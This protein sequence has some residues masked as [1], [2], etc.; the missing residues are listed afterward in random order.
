MASR[1]TRNR[2]RWFLRPSCDDDGGLAANPTGASVDVD[3]DNHVPTFLSTSSSDDGEN[4]ISDESS[5]DSDG[6]DTH[7]HTEELMNWSSTGRD[8]ASVTGDS[9]SLEDG[10]E[11]TVDSVASVDVASQPCLDLSTSEEA[12]VKLL[13]LLDGSSAPRKL[14]DKVVTL[15][16][17]LVNDGADPT[18]LY[19]RD[20]LM[21]KL[22]SQISVPN[23]WPDH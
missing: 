7:D 11:I 6:I 4:S 20:R 19:S 21:R 14:Y 8:D 10:D 12:S 3:A 1:A 23:P 18:K 16:R 2:R 9:A 5:E 17:V 15:T 13:K 22:S